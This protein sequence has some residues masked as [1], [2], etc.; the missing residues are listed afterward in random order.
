MTIKK[1]LLTILILILSINSIAAQNR[2]FPYELKKWDVLVFPLSFGS[3][4]LGESLYEDKDPLTLKEISSLK[5]NDVV[6][7]DRGATYNFSWD[8]DERSDQ[9]R[10]IVITSS[11]FLLSIPP[12]IHAKLGNILTVATMFVESCFLLGGVT[13]LTKGVVNR[14]RP[15]LYNTALSAEERHAFSDDH[16]TS[17]FSGHTATA[18]TAA[19]F[20][21]KVFTDIHGDSIWS[22]LLWGS[23]LSLA[24]LTGYARVKG[25]V[26]YPSDVIIGAAV[27]FAIGYLVPVFHRKKTGDRLSIIITPNRIGF[28]LAL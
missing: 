17:F 5:R 23:S 3:Y 13:L 22:K 9:Y 15:Y 19:T 20:I 6:G 25:G 7:F 4:L 28:R 1:T 21:S 12:L 16:S 18:F 2:Q 26:H 10:D 24:A 27:G 14:K 8:W 11:F